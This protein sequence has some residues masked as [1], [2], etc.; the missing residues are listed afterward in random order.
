MGRVVV[1]T[2]WKGGAVRS[3]SVLGVMATCPIAQDM[4]GG[5]PA[6]RRCDRKDLR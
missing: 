2:S 4:L 1:V 3:S 5:S 6:W